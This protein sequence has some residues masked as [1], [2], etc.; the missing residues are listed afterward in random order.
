[1]QQGTAAS[2]Q[3]AEQLL[4]RVVELEPTAVD[5]HLTLVD[6]A[7]RRG[8]YAGAR[9]RAIRGRGVNPHN[10]RMLLA[11]ARA[12]LGLG[13]SAMALEL[14]RA[15]L[16]ESTSD[17][18][19]LTVFAEVALATNQRG[20][21]SEAL[22][23]VLAGTA[24]NPHDEQLQRAAARLLTAL[25]RADEAIARLEQYRSTAGGDP[26]PEVLLVLAELYF[27][28]GAMAQAGALTHEA[29]ERYADHP[30]ALR[31]LVL[32]HATQQEPA[33]IQALMRDFQPQTLDEAALASLAA[34]ALA[35]AGAAYTETALQLF[36]RACAAAPESTAAQLGLAYLR[37]QTGAPDR[38]VELYRAVLAREPAN[39]RVLNDLAWALAVGQGRL[40]EA[41][42]L[43]NRGLELEPGNLHLRDT[44]AAILL[45]LP[46]R[47]DDARHDVEY[48]LRDAAADNAARARAL[49]RLA[50]ICA[51][52]QDVS[53]AR[54]HLEEARAIDAAGSVFD[55]DERRELAE[56]SALAASAG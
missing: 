18:D 15:A 1:L 17:R 40:A 7:M 32:W 11:R 8:D 56:L 54:V 51:L 14:V 2:I 52:E 42:E 28:Q 43:A 29:H 9:D 49:L 45:K 37:F 38:A 36:E 46:G 16:R 30:K 5:A 12:E 53:G 48:C 27:R 55:A 41:L 4:T 35:R 20:T 31:A 25:D 22:T 6:I 39:V 21:L 24:E 23:A 13:N 10:H 44:R 19:V 3:D 47:T 50:R 33:G 34:A 26:G